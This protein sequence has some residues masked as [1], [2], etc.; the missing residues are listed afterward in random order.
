MKSRSECGNHKNE[1]HENETVNTKSLILEKSY[2][3]N[4]WI[5]KMEKE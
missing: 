5:S 3:K 4:V 2:L 1:N